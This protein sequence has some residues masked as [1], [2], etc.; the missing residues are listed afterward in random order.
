MILLKEDEEFFEELMRR[1]ADYS[2]KLVEA[3]VKAGVDFFYPADDFAFKSGLMV[4][5][6]TVL[7]DL[8]AP[9]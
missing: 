3:A 2:V 6:E 1:S 8:E 5:P 7:P 4:D 9:L